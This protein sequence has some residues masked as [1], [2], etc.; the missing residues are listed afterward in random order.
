MDVEKQYVDTRRHAPRF[1]LRL[2]WL[3]EHQTELQPWQLMT[4]SA[5]Y[6]DIV[7]RLFWLLGF[8][9]SPR[10]A[11]LGKASILASRSQSEL[12]CAKWAR[13]T[14]SQNRSD[15]PALGRS[16][17]GS[18]LSQNGNRSSFGTHPQSATRRPDGAIGEL[19]RIPKT[20][21]LLNFI[22]D[23][24]YRRHILNQLNRGEGRG[25]LSRRVFYGQR[26]EL[27]QRYRESQ[28]DQLSALGL[29]VQRLDPLDDSPYGCGYESPACDRD[30]GKERRPRST[31]TP[32]SQALQHVRSLPFRGSRRGLKG[33]VAAAPHARGS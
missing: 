5:G 9:F 22:A 13:P 4:D 15:C 6:S 26:G 7:I 24:N 11:E 31:L 8:Q 23:Q 14:S 20:L 1:P 16:P 3:L 2:G 19:G 25:R 17:P 21:H 10:V 32:Q 29:V 33:R 28:E 30:R 27:R 12:W 18:G